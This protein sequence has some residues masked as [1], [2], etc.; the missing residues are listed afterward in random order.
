MEDVKLFDGFAVGIR[1]GRKGGGRGRQSDSPERSAR[2]GLQ[3]V[4]GGDRPKV[5]DQ[6]RQPGIT[7]RDADRVGHGQRE[8]SAGQQVSR[9]P[10]VDLRVDARRC[11]KALGLVR[12]EH[13]GAQ[14][15]QA[16]RAGEGG[17][18]QAVRAQRAP[19]QHQRAWQVV[20]AVKQADGDNEIEARFAE[21]QPVLVALHASR[22]PGEPR[23]GIGEGHPHA[24]TGQGRGQRRIGRADH[25]RLLEAA[26]DKVEPFDQLLARGPVKII[27]SG[28]G[29]GGPIAAQASQGAV[30]RLVHRRGLVPTGGR[31]DKTVMR[32]PLRLAQAAAREAIDFALPPRCPGCATIVPDPHRFCLDCWQALTFLG[33]PCCQ[34]CGLPF[35]Y[36]SG[37]AECAAC[38]ADPPRFDRLRAAVAY[39]E[40]ARAVALKLKYGGRPGLAETMAR[41]M[42]R[43][44]EGADAALTPVPL[45]R[46]RIWKRGYNQS[47]LIVRALARH[48]GLPADLN[49]LRRTKATPPL[50]GLG[51]RERAL[52]V[53][54]AF[55]VPHARRDWLKGRSVILVDDVFTSGA[56][57]DACARALKRGGA[58]KVNI[59]CW[60]RVVREG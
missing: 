52:A 51:R 48:T 1:L 54:G 31:G 39:G 28:E 41:L 37:E 9:R 42:Q 5:P 21:R 27:R 10:H 15:W 58:G 18:E 24:A 50:K 26:R 33:E 8:A 4:G 60:A 16:A 56:T 34:R 53:R 43:H 19:D 3:D 55:Q 46:W 20:H 49:L 35:P 36:D 45:H 14:A 11:G 38:L 17:Q 59:L 32:V 47:A 12:R 23:A 30:E 40:I 2:A 57:A 13:G 29:Q 6:A 22:G 44:V 7:D 25:Q